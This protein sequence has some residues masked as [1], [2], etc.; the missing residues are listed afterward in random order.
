MSPHEIADESSVI[1]LHVAIETC[2]SDSMPAYLA[3]SAVTDTTGTI[4]RSDSSL[5]AGYT[6]EG[7]DDDL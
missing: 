6:Y 1:S 5:E 4:A 3:F 2:L 7:K